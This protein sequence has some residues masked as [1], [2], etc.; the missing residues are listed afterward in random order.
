MH[1]ASRP[2]DRAELAAAATSC[3]AH[4]ERRSSRVLLHVV[5]QLRPLVPSP[6]ELAGNQSIAWI[7]CVELPL[8]S[9]GLKARLLQSELNLATLGMALAGIL[10]NG[11]KRGLDSYRPQQAQHL[12]ADALIDANGAERYAVAR[13]A[14]I[15]GCTAADVP[16]GVAILAGVAHMQLASAMSA[17][18]QTRE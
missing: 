17:T 16:A 8:C 7:D 14:V 3:Q 5:R 4:A 11:V 10:L 15:D 6:F 2:Q 13:C 1:A 18:K 12:G 9:D